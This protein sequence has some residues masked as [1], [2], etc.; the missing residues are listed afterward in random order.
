[1]TKDQGPSP[2]ILVVE[3]EFPLRN[4]IEDCLTA[5]GYRV[6]T[7]VDGQQ[8]LDKTASQKPDLVLLDVMMPKIDGFSVCTSLRRA[9]HTT[10]V[11]MLTA[12]NQV[13]DRVHG[14][15]SGADDYLA[16]PFATNELLARIR[17][18]LRRT[19]TDNEP[20][21]SLD[22]GDA[23]IDFVRMTATV[24]GADI[25]L[26]PKEFATL[27]LLATARGATVSREQFLDAVWGYAS[28]PTTRTIDNHIAKLRQKFEPDPSNPTHILTV[29]GVGYRFKSP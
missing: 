18:L 20:I 9:G 21:N 8:A 13:A 7:A 1:M 24:A 14:L 27:R 5:E 4:A 16:K 29:H 28:F 12:K 26:A 11:I 2:R 25:E 23:H 22:I 6:L 10:P 15:D 17:A 19:S 3:D